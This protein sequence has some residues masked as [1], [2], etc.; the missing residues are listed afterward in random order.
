MLLWDLRVEPQARRRGI[1][2]A[3]LAAAEGAVRSRGARSLH[4]ETQDV[5]VGAC[6]FYAR[7]GFSLDGIARGTYPQ[8]PHETRLLWTKRL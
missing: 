8:L 4:V 5:N 1:G 7:Q 2:Q 6:R 3:L